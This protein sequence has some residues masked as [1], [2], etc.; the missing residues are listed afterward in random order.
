M[1][2][3]TATITNVAQAH[4]V[5]KEMNLHGYEWGSDYRFHGR[6]ALKLILEGQMRQNIDSYLEELSSG[7]GVDRRNGSYSRHLL[8]ELGDIELQVPR[9]RRYSGLKVVRAYARRA[10]HIDRMILA[11]FV[12]GVSTRKVAEA[13]L[14]VLGERV[15]ASTVSLWPIDIECWFSMAWSWH[16]RPVREP[17]G[18]RCWWPWGSA[19]TAKKRS[20]TSV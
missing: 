3:P 9:T 1:P 4:E 13:L 10:Q 17:F 15:S 7:D 14:P 19:Q 8:T 11:C 6:A 16:A 12:L 5:I 18:V 20:L 2:Q